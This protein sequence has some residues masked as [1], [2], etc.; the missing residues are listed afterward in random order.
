MRRSRSVFLAL[1]A[2]HVVSGL[3]SHPAARVINRVTKPLLMPALAASTASLRPGVR[4]ALSLSAIGDTVLMSP[5]PAGTIGGIL[6][7]GAAHTAYLGE[8]AVLGRGA[9]RGVTARLGLGVA[10]AV[11]ATAGLL[12]KPLSVRGERA[13][14][15]PVVG[16]AGLCAA[17]A[18]AAIRAGSVVGGSRGRALVA[19]GLLFVVSDS[20]VAAALFGPAQWDERGRLSTAIMITYLTAQACLVAGLTP[21]EPAEVPTAV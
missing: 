16:Y 9:G 14:L 3:V 8:L 17:M 15:G 5:T 4:V 18:A 21:E 7:F 20:M 12:H 1:G 13:L 10:A 6:G 11:G 2:V 19:G